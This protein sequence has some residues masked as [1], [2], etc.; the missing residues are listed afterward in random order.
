MTGRLDL[1]R[2]IRT[3]TAFARGVLGP[4]Y[5]PEVPEQM[6]NTVTQLPSEKDKKALL[7]ALRM[8]D[9]KAGA[10]VL[11]GRAVPASWLTASEAEAVLQRWKASRLKMNRQ[12]AGGLI[13]ASVASLYGHPGPHW[14]RIGYP[15]PLGPAPTGP[16]RFDPI[17]V[18]SDTHLSCDVVIV[19][20]GPGGQC[21]AS[22][23]ARAGLD[24]LVVE[25]GGYYSES[26]FHHYESQAQRE[27]YLYGATLTTVDGGVRIISGST[28]GGG[29]VVNYTV[30]FH[31]P[32]RVRQQWAAISGIEAFASGEF[33]QSLDEVAARL[34]VNRDSSALNQRERFMEEGMKEL[35]WHVDQMPRN[36]KACPQDEQCGYCGFG[37]R[38]GAKQGARI[39]LEEAVAHGARILTHVDVREVAIRDGRAVGIEGTSNGHRVRL[40]ARKAV[41]VAAGS[42]ETPALL[43]RSRL[44]GQVGHHL[45]L[46]PGTGIWG[47]FEDEARPWEGVQ[48]SRYSDEIRSWDD[49]YGPI[50]ESVPIH[51]AAF[52]TV[53]PW[54]S[55]SDH[56]ERMGDYLHTSLLAPLP[57]DRTEGRITIDKQGAPRIDYT[58]NADD[59][60]RMIEAVIKGAKV[61]EASG[62]KEIWS[63]HSKRIAYRPG[64]SGGYERWADE[65]RAHGYKPTTGL[66]ASFHQMGSCRMGKDPSSSAVDEN[67]QSHE[68]K[69]L[70][71][72]DG[73]NFPDASG[74]NP[75]LSIFG[76]A[77]LAGKKLAEKLG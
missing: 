31:T 9:T 25:K 42:I 24:V 18:E 15:G 45:H 53:V 14:A 7:G 16:R 77:N 44:G 47:V 50:Y 63:T 5:T 46:H 64:Q 2:E 19:G 52:A 57:R 71:V 73:S 8:L 70:Y 39:Y 67:N 58:L 41:V 61:F 60:R 35:G 33:E 76:I 72:T 38:H 4:A 43:L 40:D 1:A 51:P 32:E 21:V 74:V 49:G 17:E 6:I 66:L 12:L 59:E 10:L 3:L 36:V 13:S 48:M 69:D 28:L 20:S 55:A 26:Q 65:I 27:L 34:N 54:T 56:H 37:C 30:S 62:A 68:V 29:A 11:T 22:H 23:L 75:M